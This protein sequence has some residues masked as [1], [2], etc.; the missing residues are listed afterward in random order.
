LRGPVS[1]Y[2][3]GD[4]IRRVV[5]NDGWQLR[6]PVGPGAA[7]VLGLRGS[8]TDEQWTAA[9]LSGQEWRLGSTRAWACREL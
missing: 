6:Y 5:K 2:V 9:A 1:P 7:P 8:I 3:V 4:A